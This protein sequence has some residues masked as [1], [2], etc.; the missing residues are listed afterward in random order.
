MSRLLEINPYLEFE[1]NHI[2]FEP[3][4]KSL[5][6]LADF[7]SSADLVICTTADEGVES[8]INQLAV[9]NKKTVLYGRAI[10]RANRDT[11]GEDDANEYR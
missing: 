5:D 4:V 7:I 6:I 3:I 8:A 10:R 11:S 2:V 9:I 1:E